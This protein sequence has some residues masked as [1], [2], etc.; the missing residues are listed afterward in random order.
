MAQT[1]NWCGEEKEDIGLEFEW[2]DRGYRATGDTIVCWDCTVNL[3]HR[4][5]TIRDVLGIEQPEP[6]DVEGDA[7]DMIRLTDAINAGPPD[8]RSWEDTFP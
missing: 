7:R 5:T 1:C 3:H 4:L 6:D 2:T 8:D